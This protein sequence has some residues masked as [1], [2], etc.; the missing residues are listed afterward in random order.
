MQ[1]CP[2]GRYRLV[3]QCQ[4]AVA[5]ERC[6][7]ESITSRWANVGEE[8]LIADVSGVRHSAVRDCRLSPETIMWPIRAIGSSFVVPGGGPQTIVRHR[9]A[10][11]TAHAQP[12]WSRNWK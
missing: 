12:S 9:S 1:K 3:L 6:R 11:A 7:P 2:A 8:F 5:H 10:T 4:D